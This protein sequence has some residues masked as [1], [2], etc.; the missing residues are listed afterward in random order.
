V[1]SR[2]ASSDVRVAKRSVSVAA[3]ERLG[4]A[5]GHA[6]HG[7]VD[8]ADV[9]RVGAGD[10]AGDTGDVHDRPVPL[11]QFVHRRTSQRPVTQC[12]QGE[13]AQP[14]GTLD[15]VHRH[16]VEGRRVV[17]HQVDATQRVHC[18]LDQP[19]ATVV[20]AHVLRHHVQPFV[21]DLGVQLLRGLRPAADREHV[22]ALVEQQPHDG[23]ADATGAAGDDRAGTLVAQVNAHR[24]PPLSIG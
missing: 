2:S 5:L 24:A 22:R 9:R 23:L 20:G 1:C 6:D 17:H 18:L 21:V 11:R 16:V 13:Q 14:V 8:G 7:R 12:L 10:D 3:G 19:R 15:L 4:H